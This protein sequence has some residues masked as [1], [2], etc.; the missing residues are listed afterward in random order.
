VIVDTHIHPLSDDPVRYPTS[1]PPGPDWYQGLHFTGDECLEQM[2]LAGVDQ[3]VLVSAYSL[4][5]YDNSFAADLAREHPGRFVGVCRIDG[6]APDVAAALDSWIEGKGMRGVR[7]GSADPSVYPACERARQLGIPVALQVT[8][9]KLGQVRLLAQ[10]F[11]DLNLILDHLAHPPTDDGP[12]YQAASEFFALRD[13][14]NLHQKFSSMNLWE[15]DAG[16][17]SRRAFVEA[18]VEH[19]GPSRLM[20]GSDFPHT[21]GTSSDPYKELVDLVRDALDFLPATDREQML[22]GT[23]RKL[24]PALGGS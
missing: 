20:W 7:F 2:A 10:A 22:A 23:A 11:P 4:Y 21:R 19:F 18:L 24:F 16:R 15:A 3:M 9:D 13:L 1:P 17:S 12:P 14:P 6:A 5:G 8:Q